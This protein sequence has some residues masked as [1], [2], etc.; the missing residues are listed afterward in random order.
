MSENKYFRTTTTRVNTKVYFIQI[1]CVGDKF[2]IK[3]KVVKGKVVK[4][5][6]FEESLYLGNFV[7]LIIIRPSLLKTV[8]L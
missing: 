1:N 8:L 7:Q 3:V 2:E 4:G 5:V 6:L